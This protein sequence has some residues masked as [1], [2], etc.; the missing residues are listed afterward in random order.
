MTLFNPWLQTHHPE[1]LLTLWQ[2]D[3][4]LSQGLTCGHSNAHFLWE[5]IL[6]FNYYT[7]Q[8]MLH[9]FLFN[10]EQISL[11]HS[12]MCAHEISLASVREAQPLCNQANVDRTSC[13][14]ISFLPMFNDFPL[15]CL[16]NSHSAFENCLNF[17]SSVI[18]FSASSSSLPCTS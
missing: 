14:V 4:H 3:K 11:V 6:F 13:Q 5:A 7:R 1:L 16:Q 10:S 9:D 15:F 8:T 18:S 2:R 17:P 12:S